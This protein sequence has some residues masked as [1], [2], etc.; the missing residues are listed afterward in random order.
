MAKKVYIGVSGKARKVKKIYIGVG[1]KARKVKK[2]Y[3]GVGGKARPFFTSGELAYYGRGTDLTYKASS[4]PAGATVGNYALIAGGANSYVT[5]YSKD[6]V[7]TLPT[8]LSS[9][10]SYLSSATVGNYALFGKGSSYPTNR[11]V[12]AYDTSLTQTI[13]SVTTQ[14]GYKASSGS[15]GNYAVF[16][17]GLEDD[18]DVYGVVNAYDTSLTLSKANSGLSA[19]RC[20]AATASVGNYL[21]ID[22]GLSGGAAADYLM[23][24]Y[25][26]SL[27]RGTTSNYHGTQS[28]GI[29]FGNY[30]IFGGGSQASNGVKVSAYNSALTKTALAD[31][32]C[33]RRFGSTGTVG[34][35]AIF[36]GGENN[37]NPSDP[38][39]L[40]VYD[41][42]LTKTVFTPA[43][44]DTKRVR[45][46]ASATIGNYLIFAGG[47]YASN[48]STAESVYVHVYTAD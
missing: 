11:V 38:I 2:A 17:G 33:H 34:E 46:A 40:D 15:V 4:G 10:M 20:E 28:R 7:Q 47:Q 18:D 26:K 12:N 3:I 48:S 6:L 35:Y 42:S 23:N 16:A 1:G 41:K 13:P 25:N 29:S 44:H 22:L 24:T 5:A 31:L 27:T 14:A 30:A 9:S 39:V 36:A 45:Y 21:L 37:T 32:S 19:S 43:L 8:K